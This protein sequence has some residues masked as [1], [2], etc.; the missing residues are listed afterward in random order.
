MSFLIALS[1][2]MVLIIIG[3][4]L[5]KSAFLPETAWGGIEKLT[6]YILFPSLLIH[7]LSRQNLQGSDWQSMLLVVVG[8]LLISAIVLVVWHLLGRSD[9]D[10]TFTSIF[11]GGVRF[12][13]YIALAVAQGLYGAAGLATGSIVVGFMVVL[14]NI[15]CISVFV[16]WG[17]SAAKSMRAFM[18]ELLINPLIIA[19]IIG[20]GL[21]LSGIGLPGFSE[22]ILE[23]IGRAALPLGLLAV[24][25]ALRLDMIKGHSRAIMKS[26]LVQFVLKPAAA[27]ALIH[28]SGVSGV[29]AVVLI[30]VF[31]TPT[32][33]S[34]YILARQLG[35]DTE[36]IASII[37]VQTLM[38]FLAMPFIA[39]LLLPLYS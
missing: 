31:I 35:G 30:L 16:I 37:T 14:I 12:N 18:R 10:A 11:Q 5:R 1:P 25:A 33:P 8:T 39:M 29:A 19:C 24:G 2:V 36:T 13:T 23:I 21:G 9:S 7:T 20:W 26:S 15:A 6:Y 3:Y 17:N 34:A 22:D 38:A 4:V 32:A 27:A 28:Y